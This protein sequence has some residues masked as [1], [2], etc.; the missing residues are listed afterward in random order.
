MR[1]LRSFHLLFE[2]VLDLVLDGL[3]FIRLTLRLQKT[4]AAENLLLRKQLALYLER[5]VKPRRARDATR[6]TLVF[7]S[8]LFAWQEALTITKPLTFIRWHRRGF[9]L[10][11]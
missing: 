7:L 11:W 10:F 2:T 4:L 6:F 5:Q 3:K 1:T 9:R 8:G